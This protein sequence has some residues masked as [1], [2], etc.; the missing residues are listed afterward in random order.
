VEAQKSHITQMLCYIF[1][2]TSPSCCLIYSILMTR[3]QHGRHWVTMKLTVRIFLI[4]LA[5]FHEFGQI[6]GKGQISTPHSY[7]KMLNQF[8]WNKNL[9]ITSWRP[10]SMGKGTFRPPQLW[11]RLTDFYEMR[12]SELSPEGQPTSKLS[13]RSN[14]VGSLH[15][16]KAWPK[17]PNFR[18]SCFPR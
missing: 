4:D 8:W 1:C 16:Y 15:E 6:N 13:F 10:K 18:D 11:N 9:R 12:I 7:K 17:R 14:N 5:I 2:Q 3:N